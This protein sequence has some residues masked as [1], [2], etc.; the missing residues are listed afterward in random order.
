[1][2]TLTFAVDGEDV[3]RPLLEEAILLK[4]RKGKVKQL[5]EGFI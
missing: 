5:Y 3:F 1:M 4:N 2:A